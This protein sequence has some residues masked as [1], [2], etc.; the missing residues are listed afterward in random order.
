MCVEFN[1]VNSAQQKWLYG[2]KNPLGRN[3]RV[4]LANE[5]PP[6]RSLFKTHLL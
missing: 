6:Y 2:G 3:Y 5:F 1:F 4:G